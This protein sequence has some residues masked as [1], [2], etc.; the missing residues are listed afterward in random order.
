MK[1]ILKFILKYALIFAGIW[2]VYIVKVWASRTGFISATT[3]G[4]G[5]IIMAVLGIIGYSFW[6]AAQKV[7]RRKFVASVLFLLVFGI[8]A[9]ILDGE[10]RV[11]T[12][13]APVTNA[14][15]PLTNPPKDIAG[16]A[17]DGERKVRTNSVPVKNP[18][19]SRAAPSGDKELLAQV[20]HE[21]KDAFGRREAAIH[22]WTNL[23]KANAEK[24]EMETA[25]LSMLNS[26]KS[27]HN[28]QCDRIKLLHNKIVIIQNKE[29]QEKAEA[30]LTLSLNRC[31]IIAET[32][33][34][35]HAALGSEFIKNTGGS[36]GISWSSAMQ[37]Q[38]E[39]ISESQ[40]REKEAIPL[41]VSALTTLGMNPD[42]KSY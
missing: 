20:I 13:S 1:S 18:V 36:V 7:S 4:Y 8:A 6:P 31:K 12:S 21:W 27:D 29:A 41:F 25:Q 10:K 5:L 37:V 24:Q 2:V 34:L 9:L 39:E 22:L 26:L 42:L 32:M 16:I 15:E 40:S 3:A 33:E 35:T 30:A 14:V 38:K 23:L 17:L 19:E 28:K 11:R